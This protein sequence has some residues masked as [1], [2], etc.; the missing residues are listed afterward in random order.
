MLITSR[1][2]LIGVVVAMTAQA[3]ELDTPIP[4][5]PS[6]YSMDEC[7][8]LLVSDLNTPPGE[9]E[10]LGRMA[11]LSQRFRGPQ[12]Y[13]GIQKNILR[14]NMQDRNLRWAQYVRPIEGEM[15]ERIFRFERA[16]KEAMFAADEE[17]GLVHWRRAWWLRLEIEAR[18]L[19]RE[20]LLTTLDYP[21]QNLGPIPFLDVFARADQKPID[22]KLRDYDQVTQF[23]DGS[24]FAWRAWNTDP[25]SEEL[26]LRFEYEVV[27]QLLREYRFVESLLFSNRVPQKNV[28]RFLGRL[29]EPLGREIE[30]YFRFK[31]TK[32]LSLMSSDGSRVE[33]LQPLPPWVSVFQGARPEHL[34]RGLLRS[35]LPQNQSFLAS[36]RQFRN[37]EDILM[38][39]LRF[40]GVRVRVIRTQFGTVEV[41]LSDRSFDILKW[42]DFGIPA[43]AVRNGDFLTLLSE[44]AV[45]Y[46]VGDE[47]WGRNHTQRFELI[48]IPEN[49]LD[50]QVQFLMSFMFKTSDVHR[51]TRFASL[52]DRAQDFTQA[53]IDSGNVAFP[54]HLVH[55]RGVYILPPLRPHRIR[56]F[57]TN[58]EC[59]SRLEESVA[60]RNLRVVSRPVPDMG[61]VRGGYVLEVYGR[62]D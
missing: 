57:A 26:R 21:L 29:L 40:D 5:P 24:Y 58:L 48:R 18:Q 59:R 17:T 1:W 12:S 46:K 44:R 42:P 47:G 3:G 16:V 37:N 54:N 20:D 22:D 25:E 14:M 28:E 27:S 13:A 4:R 32:G 50:L 34:I 7:G 53:M 56:Y 38:T 51:M 31:E 2:G 43:E 49:F 36:L 10:H 60:Q 62:E 52:S 41:V 8:P 61:F 55:P 19:K 33:D 45:L 35:K 11:W 9:L 15:I 30:A 39:G 6:F 23:F